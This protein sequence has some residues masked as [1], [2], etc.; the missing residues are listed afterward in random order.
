MPNTLFI[1]YSRKQQD[2]AIQ[3]DNIKLMQFYW[4][5]DYRIVGTV[6]WWK[7]ICEAVEESYCLVALMS[8]TYTESVYCMGEL[9]YALKLNKPILCLM[10]EP[11]VEYPKA[12]SDKQVQY[13]N[14]YDW[15]VNRVLH[16][17]LEGMHR[18]ER[19]YNERVY[20]RDLSHRPY[21]RPPV[22]TPPTKSASDEDREIVAKVH[23]AQ[24][25]PAPRINVGAAIIKATQALDEEGYEKVIDLLEPVRPHAKED[26]GAIIHDLMREARL[27]QEYAQIKV[28][29]QSSRMRGR[30]CERYKAFRQTYL[31]YPDTANLTHLCEPVGTQRAVSSVS[32]PRVIDILPKPFAWCEIPAGKVTLEEGGYI[33]KGGQTFDVPA[34]AIAKY[35]VT[36]AQYAKFIKAGGYQEKRWWTDEGWEA[37]T[38]G[39]AWD[40]SSSSFKPTGKVWT[41]PRYWTDKNFNGAEQPIVGISWYE[42]VAFC[43]WLRE[44]SGENV[45]LSTEQQWQRAAQGD[46]GR[47]YP[48]GNT[49]DKTCCNSNVDQSGIGKTTPVRQYEGKGDS[50]FK[51][52]DMS[53]N[54]FEWC[55]TDYKSGSHL[56][57]GTD[58]RVLR[59]GSWDFSDA[60]FFRCD[61]RNRGDPLN[62]YDDFGFR[63]SRS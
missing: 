33:P 27:G 16:I 41:E 10:P 55:L 24:N 47:D 44:L 37:L 50:P 45:T 57:D 34:F 4:W 1:S 35:P 62:G 53:G 32:K 51:V 56:V 3:L 36:N 8:K 15:D 12:L 31:D 58:V 28:L 60:A 19:D 21:L 29:V 46:D 20:H 61:S 11:D 25:V 63:V 23:N 14:V 13:I 2:K 40:S 38:Q 26:D 54:V 49:F 7:N 18:V 6:D 48:W 5:M 42:A 52:V 22:P 30:G 17:I 43:T 9:E 39:I 59:G